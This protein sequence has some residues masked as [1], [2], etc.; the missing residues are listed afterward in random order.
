MELATQYAIRIYDNAGIASHEVVRSNLTPTA[1]GTCR[2]S[3]VH[4]VN[5]LQSDLER[6]PIALLRSNYFFPVPVIRFA[7]VFSSPS[8]E[9]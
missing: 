6:T 7:L 8:Y 1:H 3:I 4:A 9:Y 5:S 2:S